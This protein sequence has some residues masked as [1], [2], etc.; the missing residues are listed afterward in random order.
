MTLAPPD[1]GWETISHEVAGLLADGIS[2]SLVGLPRSGRSLV[3]AAAARQLSLAGLR[4]E[5]VA[6][7]GL[8]ADRPLGALAAAGIET[9]GGAV[10]GQTVAAL[11]KL[12]GP[13]VVLAVDDADQLDRTSA[14]AI[15]AAQARVGCAVLAVSR[16]RPWSAEPGAALVDGLC[17]CVRLRL[18]PMGFDQSHALIHR[19]LPGGV[20]ADAVARLAVFSGGLPAL[21]TASVRQGIRH[22]ALVRRQGVWQVV[23]P[24]HH[25]RLAAEI[26]PLLRGL[27]ESARVGLTELAVTGEV[28]ETEAATLI[29]ARQVRRLMAFG[30]LRRIDGLDHPGLRVFPP[31]LAEHLTDEAGGARRQ[32]I[33]WPGRAPAPEPGQPGPRLDPAWADG[34]SEVDAVVLSDRVRQ[35]WRAES[36]RLRAAWEADPTPGRALPLIHAL[37]AAGEAAEQR[38]A[39][40]DQTSATGDLGQARLLIGRALDQAVDQGDPAAAAAG[41]ESAAAALPDFAPLFRLTRARCQLLRQGPPDLSAIDLPARPDPATAVLLGVAR[42][43]VAIVQGRV[44]DVLA[45]LDRPA[46]ELDRSASERVAAA[47][48][49]VPAPAQGE[50][51]PVGLDRPT[52]GRAVLPAA[53]GQD[54]RASVHRG[55]ALLFAGRLDEAVSWSD[56]ALAAARQALE[57]DLIGAH[58]FVSAFARLLAGRFRQAAALAASALILVVGDSAPESY[59]GSLLA[60]AAIAASWQG[61]DDHAA[62]LA[63][64]SRGLAGEGTYPGMLAQLAPGLVRR[65][66]PQAP[67]ALWAVVDDRLD[68]GYDLVGVLAAALAVEIH[69]DVE[70]CRRAERVARATQSDLL[71]TL[72][73]YALAVST[74]DEAGL[75]QV[76]D[77]MRR[78]GWGLF[79]LRAGVRLALAARARG[80]DAA[81]R[82]L[83]DETWHG[84][85]ADPTAKRVAFE[86]VL[87]AIDLSQ[88]EREVAGLIA[89]GRLPTEIALELSLSVRTVENHIA[90]VYRKAKVS[91]RGQLCQALGGWLSGLTGVVPRD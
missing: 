8:L 26:E 41:L 87:E 64:Q 50:R 44:E 55:L 81:F 43:E 79:A 83:T 29:G 73:R 84:L 7:L 52:P 58:A 12:L 76:F 63:D 19:L 32:P 68:R 28:L 47:P 25:P 82:R 69:P 74:G 33:Q 2:V 3:L 22:G 23:A 91:S 37:R 78:A 38:R 75:G 89:S 4:V 54:G 21:V 49:L 67:R 6:G 70:R 66:D 13:K 51:A 34:L 1:T 56:P 20:G 5:R 35:H 62:R 42:I 88:R 46:S 31:A 48:E 80:D 27:D 40:W 24:L 60:L 65:R 72:G 36:R 85:P 30:L 10:L 77:R 14:G 16:R 45:E 15:A 11:V 39:V 57:P 9:G 17:P 90:S 18:E 53:V 71:R 61:R 86:P 59:H